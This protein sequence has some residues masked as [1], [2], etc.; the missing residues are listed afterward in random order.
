M[1]SEEQRQGPT[2]GFTIPTCL[3]LIVPHTYSQLPCIHCSNNVSK[4]KQSIGE[5]ALKLRGQIYTKCMKLFYFKTHYRFLY[6]YM[7]SHDI[8]HI[9]TGS[10]VLVAPPVYSC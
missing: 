7:T 2:Q 10:N 3:Q 1:V 5:E 9:L 4:V 8:M 6:T